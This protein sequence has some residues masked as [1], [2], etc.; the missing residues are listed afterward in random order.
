MSSRRK[1]AALGG[2]CGAALQ[3]R[4]GKDAAAGSSGACQIPSHMR[5]NLSQ[6][7][8]LTLRVAVNQAWIRD[9]AAGPERI[10]PNSIAYAFEFVTPARV[11]VNQPGFGTPPPLFFAVEAGLIGTPRQ[12]RSGAPAQGFAL[13]RSS[14]AVPASMVLFSR[15][16]APAFSSM[17][18][19]TVCFRSPP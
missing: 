19:P 11:A 14:T 8:A 18:T 16:T 5:S 12:G 13:R 2:A 10:M 15:A 6:A 4:Y 1:T 9:A 3:S 7:R 17:R